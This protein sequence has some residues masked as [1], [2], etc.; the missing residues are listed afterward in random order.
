MTTY[1]QG[2]P[3]KSSTRIE[4]INVEI[5]PPREDAAIQRVRETHQEYVRLYKQAKAIESESG[6]GDMKKLGAV[7]L[8]KKP[9]K[10]GRPIFVFTPGNLPT[11]VD[12]ERVVMY[13]ILLMHDTVMRDNG[14]YTALWVCNNL[15]SSQL[16]YFWFRR[17]YKMVPYEYRKN[18][19]CLTLLHPG[20]SVRLLLLLLSYMLKDTFWEK[21][22]FAE[23]IEFLDEVV[24][25]PTS[26]GLQQ[27]Y[28]IY[29]RILDKEHKEMA[30]RM[31]KEQMGAG[32][33][34]MGGMGMGMG[35]MMGGMM[36][37]GGMGMGASY[38]PSP[39][40]MD[41]VGDLGKDGGKEML[42][43]MP[44]RPYRK[45]Y[46][47]DDEES[48]SED[49]D[50]EAKTKAAELAKAGLGPP[51]S[52]AGPAPTGASQPAERPYRK[53]FA[54]DSEEEESDEEA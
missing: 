24:E 49:E 15:E 4:E 35:G 29:D 54:A 22:E 51:P 13:G 9:D 1:V 41:D 21:L 45:E 25:D 26:L 18:M 19:R 27:D 36:G 44:H 17:T 16:G 38:S 42:G 14:E 52:A 33:M 6:F 32:G 8:A 34:G 47:R 7:R 23:R 50:E 31:E 39:S 3:A 10:H 11:G 43:S 40:M 48:E 20:I 5:A 12:L 30:E 46:L 37:M 2:V 53:E 28:Y